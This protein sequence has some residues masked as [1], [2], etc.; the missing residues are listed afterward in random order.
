MAEISRVKPPIWFWIVCVIALVWNI[1]GIGAYF[2]QVSM[3][4][5]II[6]ALPQEQQDMYANL[7]VWYM[8]VFALAVFGGTLGCMGLLL[9]KKWAYLILLISAVAVV[10]QMSYV[11]FGIKM[12]NPMT[13]LVIIVSFALV[14]FSK[15]ATKKGW[16]N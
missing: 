6:A 5:E 2:A 13:P 7:P 10:I 14:Y 11:V 4:S 3:T 15:S 9:R 8:I 12:P 1:L 16:L